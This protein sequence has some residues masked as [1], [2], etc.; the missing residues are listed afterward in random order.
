MPTPRRTTSRR[1][2]STPGLG[3]G[4]IRW[5]WRLVVRHDRRPV[6]APVPHI[7]VNAPVMESELTLPPLLGVF[8]GADPGVVPPETVIRHRDLSSDEG[9]TSRRSSRIIVSTDGTV[10]R[11]KLIS[12]PHDIHESMVLSAIKSWR[13]EPATKDG[14]PVRYRLLMP[15]DA[16]R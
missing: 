13:F 12:I 14:H 6:F 8:D 4:W 2:I 5:P 1:R 15:V 16:A 7:G 3:R 11:S 9:G 10:E